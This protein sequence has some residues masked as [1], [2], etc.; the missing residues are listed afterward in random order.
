MKLIRLQQD[1]KR[2]PTQVTLAFQQAELVVVQNPMGVQMFVRTNRH[3]GSRFLPN[4]FIRSIITERCR[5][6]YHKLGFKNLSVLTASRELGLISGAADEKD[7]VPQV[8]ASGRNARAASVSNTNSS[9][10]YSLGA[11]EPA[12]NGTS[13]AKSLPLTRSVDG[14]LNIVQVERAEFK[15]P[16]FQCRDELELCRGEGLGYL[17]C[18][19]TMLICILDLLVSD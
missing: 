4:L 17:D 16:A 1:T 7:V 12:T 10:R 11:V 5:S 9:P 8:A 3:R 19:L 13:S 2:E 6:T 15:S 14:L 18:D